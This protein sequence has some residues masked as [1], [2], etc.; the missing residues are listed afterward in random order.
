MDYA[1][2]LAVLDEEG[3]AGIVG[4]RHGDGG[5]VAQLRVV[6]P[7]EGR[8]APEERRDVAGAAQGSVTR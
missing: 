1:E 4:A 5:D 7:V 8:V 2:G 6:E 3:G